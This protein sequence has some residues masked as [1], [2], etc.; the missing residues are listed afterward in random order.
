MR[1]DFNAKNGEISDN[2]IYT[3]III[4][5][6]VG[7]SKVIFDNGKEIN[8]SNATPIIFAQYLKIELKKRN[9]IVDINNYFNSTVI[10]FAHDKKYRYKDMYIE[11]YNEIIKVMS[12]EDLNEASVLEAKEL[13]KKDMNYNFKISEYRATMKFMELFSD[14][15]FSFKKLISDLW[16]FDQKNL[17]V[18]KKYMLNY[19]NCLINISE[20]I[21]NK[22]KLKNFK[23]KGEKFNYLY[24][25]KFNGHNYIVEKARRNSSFIGY[26][27]KEFDNK[28]KHYDYAVVLATGYY[29]FGD[30]FE[31]HK[32]RKE[33]GILGRE[34]ECINNIKKI[35]NYNVGKFEDFKNNIMESIR[36]LYEKDRKEFYELLSKLNGDVL[37]LNEIIKYMK[38]LTV[39]DVIKVIKSSSFV[40]F[41]INFEEV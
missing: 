17:E 16:I 18:F 25:P 30:N 10:S 7:H 29:L 33:I 39:G 22:E 26:L 19:E 32:S 37:D 11:K 15:T 38:T 13:A 27:F 3:N 6:G 34:D 9:I 35:E 31:V 5:T 1:F 24:I 41:K 20:K 2:N 40:N 36:R 12:E 21:D 23:N 4:G 28:N 8:F 14:Y